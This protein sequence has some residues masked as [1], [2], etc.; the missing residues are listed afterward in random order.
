[1]EDDYVSEKNFWPDQSLG[2]SGRLP[3]VYQNY[4][5]V[6]PFPSLRITFTSPAL[7]IPGLLQT[8]FLDRIEG[9]PHVRD[10]ILD[11]MS[12]GTSVTAKVN[13]TSSSGG[14]EAAESRP[15]WLHC[16]PLFGADDNVGVWMV[17]IVEREEITGRL[18]SMALEDR[19]PTSS[20]PNT[21]TRPVSGGTAR[22]ASERLYQ[23]YLKRQGGERVTTDSGYSVD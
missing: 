2:H 18:N 9:P 5:L 23:D 8:K 16:T 22:Q 17:V 14:R 21:G 7:R 6:R 11:A 3:G 13:W 20:R 1:M 10:G 19:R 12:H 15:R 4:L